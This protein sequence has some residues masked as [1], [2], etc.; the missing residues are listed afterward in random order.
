MEHSLPGAK[1]PGNDSSRERKFHGTFTPGNESSRERKY[2]G[3]FA[4]GSESST[5]WN[6]RS[7]ERKFLGAKVPVT[8][9]RRM[10]RYTIVSL[11][12]TPTTVYVNLLVSTTQYNFRFLALN[13]VTLRER[14]GSR[15]FGRVCLKD[16]GTGDGTLAIDCPGKDYHIGTL[17]KV[18]NIIY[19][20]NDVLAE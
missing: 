7:W 20:M 17:S 12:T 2:H 18:N 1:V 5:L 19:C 6:F 10:D 15:C 8:E 4:P 16:D 14:Y 13:A 9:N 3:T 11:Q